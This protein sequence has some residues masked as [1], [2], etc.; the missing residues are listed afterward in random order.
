MV[1]NALFTYHIFNFL[2]LKDEFLISSHCLT[3]KSKLLCVKINT[4]IFSKK[5]KQV[6]NNFKQHLKDI[7][8]KISLPFPVFQIISNMHILLDSFLVKSNIVFHRTDFRILF[9]AVQIPWNYIVQCT[10]DLM[11]NSFMMYMNAE[12]SFLF[13]K[14]GFHSLFEMPMQ[15]CATGSRWFAALFQHGIQLIASD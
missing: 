6:F 15:H 7:F 4:I 13:K 14:K 12:V 3:I 5:L 8:V 1:F 9:M 10:G 11:D 2:K